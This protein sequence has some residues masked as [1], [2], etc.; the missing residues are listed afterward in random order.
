MIESQS[1]ALIVSF[2]WLC[3]V[4][5]LYFGVQRKTP[6]WLARLSVILVIATVVRFVPLLLLPFGASYDVESFQRVGQALLQGQEV[7][8]SALVAGRHPYLPMQLYLIGSAWQMSVITATPFVWWL[9][10][11]N[12]IADLAITVLLYKASLR[13]GRAQLTAAGVAL[14]YGVSPVAML[15]SAYHGQFDSLTLLLLLLAWC[16]WQFPPRRSAISALWLGLS[17]LDKTWP[18]LFLPVIWLRLTTWRA[19]IVYPLVALGV[20]LGGVIFYL[21]V[22]RADPLQMLQRPLTHLGVPGYWGVGA[23]LN[24]MQ[25]AIGYGAELLKAI[26]PLGRYVL[27]GGVIV[28]LWLTRR[29]SIMNAWTTILLVVYVLTLGFG[30]Q[31]LLW[32]IPFAAWLI[33]RRWLNWFTLGALLYLSVNYYGYH[34]DDLL[35]RTVGFAWTTAILQLVALPIWAVTIAWLISRWRRRSSMYLVELP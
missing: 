5:L 22:W 20:P 21:L 6:S 24:V 3:G 26:A 8:A 31:Y 27:A 30:L 4:T 35:P 1:L 28:A 2:G 12:V 14:L 11:P 10:A 23:V 16:T 13:I 34:M 33:D 29:Q 7:Y 18:V 17:I 15:I 32:I 25:S 9:K 19:R